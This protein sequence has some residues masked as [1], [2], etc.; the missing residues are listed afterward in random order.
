MYWFPPSTL[1]ICLPCLFLSLEIL[2][3][4]IKTGVQ[5]THGRHARYVLLR[6]DYWKNRMTFIHFLLWPRAIWVIDLW[7]VHDCSLVLSCHPQV[8]LVMQFEKHLRTI[9][10]A[11]TGNSQLGETEFVL[12]RHFRWLFLCPSSSSLHSG[13]CESNSAPCM[14][15]TG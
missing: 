7:T 3:K 14:Q 8:T 1:S 11:R 9:L 5:S 15:R 6:H 10:R 2:K 12:R 13:T 4:K